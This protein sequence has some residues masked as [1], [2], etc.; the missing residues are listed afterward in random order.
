MCVCFRSMTHGL[1]VSTCKVYVAV[2]TSKQFVN[3]T[4]III[5]F[6]IRCL[7]NVSTVLFLKM[8]ISEKSCVLFYNVFLNSTEDCCVY[9]VY[10][11]R[12]EKIN[13]QVNYSNSTFPFVFQVKRTWR[14]NI[15][16]SGWW[17]SLKRKFMF[18]MTSYL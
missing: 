5:V 1:E 4:N 3:I 9:L 2:S 16:A 17:V 12:T 8:S 6:S 11:N 13:V 18:L 10:E 14:R 7:Q 15:S